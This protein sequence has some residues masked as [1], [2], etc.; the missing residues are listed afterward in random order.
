MDEQDAKEM[1]M[2]M[3][4]EILSLLNDP[5]LTAR[6]VVKR[7]RS[8]TGRDV[9]ERTVR[10]ARNDREPAMLRVLGKESV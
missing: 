8:L 7:L 1:K 10:K 5:D 9:T 3:Q 6:E 4:S 2:Q